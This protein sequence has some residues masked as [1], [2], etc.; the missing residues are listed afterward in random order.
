MDEEKEG[1]QVIRVNVVREI[2]S[3]V[4]GGSRWILEA[5]GKFYVASAI[6]SAF[7]TGRPECLIFAGDEE[8]NITS[9]TDL[10]G[11]IGMSVY[12][13]VALFQKVLNGEVE[14]GLEDSPM[15]VHADGDPFTAILNTM[16]AMCRGLPPDYYEDK[17]EDEDEEDF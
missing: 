9:H 2:K 8:G 17:D 13:A 5:D 15:M 10:A 11:G 12:D 16:E 6:P 3:P 7:D 14:F 1:I 4:K